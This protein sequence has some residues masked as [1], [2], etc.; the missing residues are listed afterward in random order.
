MNSRGFAVAARRMGFVSL[1]VVVSLSL[2]TMC[3][4]ALTSR[5]KNTSI[6]LGPSARTT[7]LSRGQGR[8]GASGVVDL[9]NSPADEAN[10]SFSPTGQLVAFTSDGFDSTGNGHI[11]TLGVRRILYTMNADGSGLKGYGA[12]TPTGDIVCLAWG[13]T[14]TTVYTVVLSAG[15]YTIERVNLTTSTATPLYSP[16]TGRVANLCVTPAGVIFFD[17]LDATGKWQIDSLAPGNTIATVLLQDAYDNRHPVLSNSGADLVFESNR[18]GG[19]FRIYRMNPNGGTPTPLTSSNSPGDDTQ[20]ATTADGR[21]VFSSTRYT[22]ASDHLADANIWVMSYGLEGTGSPAIAP[23][24]LFYTDVNDVSNQ[25][26]PA[27]QTDLGHAGDV[28]YVSNQDGNTELYLGSMNNTNPPYIT[29]APTVTPQLASPGDTLTISVPVASQNAGIRAVWLQIKDPDP[30]ALDIQGVNH[31][32]TSSTIDVS[33]QKVGANLVTTSLPTVKPIEFNPYDPNGNRYLPMGVATSHPGYYARAGASRLFS[34]EGQ[35]YPEIAPQWLQ[36]YDDGTHGDAIPNDGIYTCQWTT[37]NIR[38]DWYFDIIVED[39]A[40]IAHDALGRPHGNRQRFDN[41]AGCSTASFPGGKRLLLVDDGLDGQRFL[42]QGLPPVSATYDAPAFLNSLYYFVSGNTQAMR[43]PFVTD[44]EFGGADVWR[45]LCRGPVP[46]DVLQAYLPTQ[47]TQNDPVSGDPTLVHH[48][49]KAVVWASPSGWFRLIAPNSGSLQETAVQNSLRSFSEQGGRLFVIGADLATGLT[50]QG[51]NSTGTFLHDLFGADLVNQS[52][53]LTGVAAPRNAFYTPHNILNSEIL[54]GAWYGASLVAPR[55]NDGTTRGSLTRNNNPSQYVTY[56]PT[57]GSGTVCNW[58]TVD[59]VSTSSTAAI[60]VDRA[61]D[62]D[63][64]K[65]RTGSARIPYSGRR[66]AMRGTGLVEDVVGVSNENT[67][68]GSRCVLWTFGYE[69]IS[70]L[71]RAQPALDTLEWLMDGSIAG[72]V[73]QINSLQPVANA[74]IVVADSLGTNLAAAR[75][76]ARGNYIVQGIRPGSG[77]TVTVSAT[78]YYGTTQKTVGVLGGS[79]VNNANTQFFLYRDVNTCTVYGYVTEKNAPVIGAI[80]TATPLGGGDI[81]TTTTDSTGRFTITNLP[82]GTYTMVAKH[83]NTNVQSASVSVTVSNGETRRVTPDLQFDAG[84]VTP[85]AFSGLVTGNGAALI[86]ATVRV[87]SGGQTLQTVTTD[88]NGAFS[89]PGLASGTYSVETSLA[90]FVTDTRTVTYDAT[91]GLTLTISLTALSGDSTKIRMS[92]RVYDSG[93]LTPLGGATITIMVGN[94][95]I[96]Q[97][98]SQGTFTTTVPPSNFSTVLS[99][100]SYRVIVSYPGRRSQQRTVNLAPN[101]PADNLEFHMDPLL[102]ISSGVTLISLPGTYLDNMGQPLDAAQIITDTQGLPL[103]LNNNLATYDTAS[104]SYTLYHTGT[105]MPIS[106]ATAYWI[107]LSTTGRVLTAGQ[108]ADTTQPFVRPLGK[109]WNLV[110]NPYPFAV[111]LYECTVQSESGA[112]LT[113]SQAL[114]N[115]LV[116]EIVYTWDGRQYLPTTMMQPYL[117]Y[118]IFTSARCTLLISNRSPLRSSAMTPSTRTTPTATAWRARLEVLAG[119]CRDTSNYFGVIRGTGNGSVARNDSRKPPLPP[120]PYVTLSFQHDDWGSAAGDFATDIQST[121]AGEMRWLVR[122]ATNIG[123]ADV[124][125]RWPE[126]QAQL[127]NG[128]QVLL[129]DRVTQQ[130][131]Y[132]N[133]TPQYTFHAGTAGTTRD[134]DLIVSQQSGAL[135]VTDVRGSATRGDT[136]VTYTLSDAAQVRVIIRGQTGRIL[137]TLASAQPISAGTNTLRWDGRDDAGRIV[138]RGTY[139]CEVRAVTAQ[140]RTARG[141][142]LLVVPIS[143]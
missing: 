26:A 38:S 94:A 116:G 18:V 114:D 130:S 23:Q 104:G 64:G 45:I 120:G 19:R 22:S 125:M 43:S 41:V 58:D 135:R 54:L 95:V 56:D 76:D 59:P 20:P 67:S 21:L 110:G 13:Q 127:P 47:V 6:V 63:L 4:G 49:N 27:P 86:G 129:R 84:S 88:V 17:L 118:W 48:A 124:V 123:N 7:I 100:G 139:L 55:W 42:S 66:H 121:T 39:D 111:D 32:I 102:T 62:P 142:G 112:S 75:S 90:G 29:A 69:H 141:T 134:F 28:V 53:T 82:S 74:L 115:H 117:G 79:V 1:F 126:L 136:L 16:A 77:Y 3:W 15:I 108:D 14:D 61:M 109:G 57:T 37:P 2:V 11:D 131:C 50:A 52:I 119:D 44:S 73:V 101:T 70:I 51:T 10:P 71:D 25:T 143:R 85:G 93:T 35:G 138:P 80:V 65:S 30:A 128:S 98:V 8:Q 87:S 40:N 103:D 68:A 72:T 33:V 78:G 12:A 105:L 60:I 81:L 99:A 106:A 9:T 5:P 96:D 89:I 113:W 107:N 97:R 140:G 46:D 31:V 132:L 122:V 36:M 24:P 83:P 91:N 34:D 137:R 133:T 92:G